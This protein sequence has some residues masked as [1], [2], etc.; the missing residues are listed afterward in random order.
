MLRPRRTASP[1]GPA[2]I[3]LSAGAC[4]VVAPNAAAP[5]AVAPRP[6]RRTPSPRT[7]P[8]IAI[9]CRERSRRI[10]VPLPV[11]PARLP[12]S[13]SAIMLTD[14]RHGNRPMILAAWN[15]NS[16][17]VRLPRLTG[18]ARRE[19]SPTS[20]ACRRRSSRTTSFRS[21]T[22]PPPATRRTSPGRRPTT[23]W[24][25][26]SREGLAATDVTAGIPGHGDDAEA[27]HRGDDRRRARHR[28]LRAERPVGRLGQVSLQARLV[29]G[30]GRLRARR[31]V[32]PRE[33]RGDGR[34]QRRARRPRRARSRAVGGPGAV[35]GAGARRVPRDSSRPD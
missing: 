5:P 17:N 4:N 26:S 13:V 23:A 22:S 21:W 14:K 7:A 16:L 32:A 30:R 15:V 11:T 8:A 33:R 29:R 34:L 9:Q 27:R 28:L 6:C 31:I 24:P 3:V 1:S 20:S 10:V 18:V 25:Y 12:D 2:G 19:P 35:L